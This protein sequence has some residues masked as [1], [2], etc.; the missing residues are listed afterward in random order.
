MD[1]QHQEDLTTDFRTNRINPFDLSKEGPGSA[2]ADVDGDGWPD[3]AIGGGI[4]QPIVIAWGS[5]SGGFEIRNADGLPGSRNQETVGIELF[6][7]D[8]DGDTDLLAAG[9]SDRMTGDDPSWRNLLYLWTDERFELCESCLPAAHAPTGVVVPVDRDLD[10]DLD[11][12][13]GERQVRGRYGAPAPIRL[14][15]NDGSGGFQEAWRD[16]IGML[17]DAIILDEGDGRRLVVVG[18]W[19]SPRIYDLSASSVEP[20]PSD[21]FLGSGTGLWNCVHAV[22]WDQ[23]GR[24]DLA[25]GNLGTN[26]VLRASRRSPVTLTLADF[27]QSGQYEPVIRHVHRGHEGYFTSRTEFCRQMPTFNSVYRTDREFADG[28]LD[29]ISGDARILAT[30]ELNELRSG[31]WLRTDDGYRFDP[32][33]MEMQVAPVGSIT[34]VSGDTLLFAGNASNIFYRLGGLRG[35]SGLLYGPGMD[36]IEESGMML[37]SVVRAVHTIELGDETL[38]GVIRN[39]DSVRFFQR[40]DR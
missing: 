40:A 15:T 21:P 14:L 34:P 4:G 24:Q 27:D 33:P 11:L 22:D 32:F 37:R 2:V 3:L 28:T 38:W 25:M 26:T 1:W 20:I 39:Q 12:F 23:D 29:D 36:R 8:G 19:M 30:V 16:S 5:R 18:E 9:G 7:A 31:V 17:T 35:N 6:D 10:G 13:V